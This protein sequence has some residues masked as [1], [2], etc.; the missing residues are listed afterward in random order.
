MKARTCCHTETSGGCAPLAVPPMI[1]WPLSTPLSLPWTEP[2]IPKPR[3]RPRHLRRHRLR[4]PHLRPP[5]RRH[6]HPRR[7][8]RHRDH[9]RHRRHAFL[10]ITASQVPWRPASCPQLGP[11]PLPGTSATVPGTG[12]CTHCMVTRPW[13]GPIL[14]RRH[15]HL[16][17][18]RPARR[19]PRL[20]SRHRRRNRRH[21]RRSH[22]CR[23]HRRR[24]H[25][26]PRSRLTFPSTSSWATWTTPPPPPSTSS[27][28]VLPSR[29]APVVD[30]F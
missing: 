30:T 22:R 9:H 16:R 11:P 24:R 4:R 20:R 21:R 27:W 26:S 3:H 1:L 18:R 15:R 7:R 8:H 28:R 29:M 5:A 12:S 2:R 23:R 14:C 6:L 19:R 25:P 17:L 10:G 13:C